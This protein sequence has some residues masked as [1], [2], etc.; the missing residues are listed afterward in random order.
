MLKL[1]NIYILHV[2]RKQIVTCQKAMFK[3]N[4]LVPMNKPYLKVEFFGFHQIKM[5]L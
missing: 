2:G 5:R 3:P 1:L 4:P